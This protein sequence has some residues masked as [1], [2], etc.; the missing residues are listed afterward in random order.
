MQAMVELKVSMLMLNLGSKVTCGV[1]D[2]RW[3]CGMVDLHLCNI[4]GANTPPP[5]SATPATNCEDR[6]TALQ[7]LL[8]LV[9][10]SLKLL[11]GTDA[12][13]APSCLHSSCAA[14]YVAPVATNSSALSWI[15]RR[16]ATSRLPRA[17]AVY[18]WD[19]GYVAAHEIGCLLVESFT[20]VVACLQCSVDW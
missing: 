18:G 3:C 17:E 1:G 2:W 6:V 9:I 4:G 13:V 15:S 7:G 8:T 16:R 12:S 11:L 10:R 5:P 20:G 14:M 19:Q